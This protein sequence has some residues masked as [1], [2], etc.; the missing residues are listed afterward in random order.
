MVGW[1]QFGGLGSGS[2]T[3]E[4]AGKLVAKPGSDPFGFG[5]PRYVGKSVAE[6]G[7]DPI[8]FGNRQ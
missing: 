8:G 7:F 5:N 6:P 4:N 1:G 3:R 2:A